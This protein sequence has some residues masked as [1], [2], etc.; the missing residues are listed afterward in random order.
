[1]NLLYPYQYLKILSPNIYRIG[2][3]DILKFKLHGKFEKDKRFKFEIKNIDTPVFS[4]NIICNLYNENSISSYIFLTPY[5]G[6]IINKNSDLISNPK[7]ILNNKEEQNWLFDIKT[8]FNY[9]YNT[10]N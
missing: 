4:N 8:N 3:N 10:Y 6:I 2:L 9:N 7:L 5:N 1:M